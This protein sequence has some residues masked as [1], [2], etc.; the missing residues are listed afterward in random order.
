MRGW[1]VARTHIPRRQRAAVVPVG[2]DADVK[3]AGGPVAARRVHAL[4]G[5][6]VPIDF[7]PAHARC[8][9][10]RE[11]ECKMRVAAQNKVRE[12]T[13]TARKVFLKFR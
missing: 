12:G 3:L 7:R 5:D 4:P 1:N 6:A 11:K 8:C 13:R 2:E 9:A 10:I